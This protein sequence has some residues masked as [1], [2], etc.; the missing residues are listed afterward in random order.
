[1][2]VSVICRLITISAMV[3]FAVISGTIYAENTVN[4]GANKVSK[5]E[6]IDLLKPRKPKVKIVPRGLKLNPDAVEAEKKQHETEAPRSLS[7]LVNFEFDSAKLTPAAIE[8]LTPLAQALS[9]DELA[10][11]S[12][13]LE[14]HTDASGSDAYNMALSERRAASVRT[15]LT[16]YQLDASRITAYGKG[17]TELLDQ[18]APL[19]A[20]N[21]RVVVI[22]Q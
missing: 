19:A 10:S 8:R 17:E 3:F 18:N 4:L 21:R 16:Q 15:F 1:M 9:S 22:A 20:K 14:G 13:T 12:F 6:I 2:T 5:E 7:L 11:L